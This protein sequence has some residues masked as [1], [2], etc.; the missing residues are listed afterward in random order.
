MLSYETALKLKEAGFPQRD[1]YD[2]LGI[3]LS[4][5]RNNHPTGGYHLVMDEAYLIEKIGSENCK[6]RRAC[7]FKLEYLANDEEIR[8][9]MVYIPTLS[10]LI[11]ACGDN[12][13]AIKRDDLLNPCDDKGKWCAVKEWECYY[14]PEVTEGQYGSSPEEAVAALYLAINKK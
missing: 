1:D 2:S 9:L 5:G 13:I 10:E 14:P 6:K 8:A 12:L 7:S 4:L 3:E 11:E